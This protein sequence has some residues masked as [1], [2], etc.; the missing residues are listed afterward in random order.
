MSGLKR[1]LKQQ[2]KEDDRRLLEQQN[3]ININ[4][5]DD[6]QTDLISCYSD[7]KHENSL[8]QKGKDFVI[9]RRSQQLQQ[10]L[11]NCVANTGLSPQQ[12]TELT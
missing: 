9:H 8:P 1:N 6:T 10:Y 12:P 4:T 5:N 3:V 11:D 7:D 2:A